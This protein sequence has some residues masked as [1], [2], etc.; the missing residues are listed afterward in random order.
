MA[1]AVF[2]PFPADPK[3]GGSGFRFYVVSQIVD[4]LEANAR[5]CVAGEV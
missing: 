5:G 4:R 1:S 2:G 3:L